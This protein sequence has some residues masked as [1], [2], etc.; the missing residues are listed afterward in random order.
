MHKMVK[1]TDAC[2]TILNIPEQESTLKLGKLFTV[3]SVDQHCYD[4]YYK[5]SFL[6]MTLLECD[7]ILGPSK[8][9]F[10]P[11]FLVIVNDMKTLRLILSSTVYRR[12]KVQHMRTYH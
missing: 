11:D 8:R 4:T 7:S 2:V 5:L 1:T 10:N 12:W 3:K 6:T 9:P